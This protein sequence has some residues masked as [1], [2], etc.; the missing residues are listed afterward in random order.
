MDKDYDPNNSE[1]FEH[2]LY[3][4]DVKSYKF[5]RYDPTVPYSSEV[6]LQ[7]A[8]FKGVP[9]NVNT[10]DAIHLLYKISDL[11]THKIQLIHEIHDR[12]ISNVEQGSETM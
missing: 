12:M 7:Y 6:K 1:N 9:S 5:Q 8:G 4:S 2:F 3:A 10:E 11:T